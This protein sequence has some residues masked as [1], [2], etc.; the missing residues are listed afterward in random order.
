M[1]MKE[2]TKAKGDKMGGVPTKTDL[3]A[4]QL[5]QMLYLVANL[6]DA[7]LDRGF[8]G[9]VM[10][11]KGGKASDYTLTLGM[12]LVEGDAK[13]ARAVGVLIDYTKAKKGKTM[14]IRKMKKLFTRLAAGRST[15]RT[16][17]YFSFSTPKKA[18]AATKLLRDYGFEIKYKPGSKGFE[19]TGLPKA[20]KKTLSALKKNLV[21][22]SKHVYKSNEEAAQAARDRMRGK[23]TDAMFLAAD[24]S[25]AESLYARRKKDAS[26]PLAGKIRTEAEKDLER[27][28]EHMGDPKR[29][30]AIT[31]TDVLERLWKEHS[32]PEHWITIVGILE[33]RQDIQRELAARIEAEQTKVE[34]LS[35]QSFAVYQR[36][37][38]TG[39]FSVGEAAF[40]AS[41]CNRF[42]ELRKERSPLHGKMRLGSLSLEQRLAVVHTLRELDK[43]PAS[44][45]LGKT[46]GKFYAHLDTQTHSVL[47]IGFSTNP[48][49]SKEYSRE[50]MKSA[51]AANRRDDAEFK[52]ADDAART[53]VAQVKP[54]DYADIAFLL[55]SGGESSTKNFI[56]ALTS[57]K[58]GQPVI[59][60][61]STPT[62]M[63][64]FAAFVDKYY[65]E[66]E[67][68]LSRS[69]GEFG[70]WYVEVEK[71]GILLPETGAQWAAANIG[72]W[73][74]R[75]DYGGKIAS[76]IDSLGR[77]VFTVTVPAKKNG[78]PG[79][80]PTWFT[81]MVDMRGGELKPRLQFESALIQKGVSTTLLPTKV[82]T[83]SEY[84]RGKKRQVPV[85]HTYTI[86]LDGTKTRGEL[87]AAREKL[88]LPKKKKVSSPYLK[89]LDVGAPATAVARR[90]R[91]KKKKAGDEIARVR[92]NV[93]RK[94]GR[95]KKP[96]KKKRT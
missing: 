21:A 53:L 27:L 45:P 57:L 12:S 64:R 69:P 29:T 38:D 34:T 46:F 22:H 70:E 18:R 8:A 80:P 77:E 31:G 48:K 85:S 2:R 79:S 95:K 37:M 5:E 33:S 76:A 25:E 68:T 52:A 61:A 24:K 60:V 89:P 84:Y 11:K 63:A 49:Y 59:Y 43:L 56:Y 50:G 39:I 16:D 35:P 73:T 58:R 74:N 9:G 26:T 14:V 13:D 40:V 91:G 90:G 94:L 65:P 67:P 51:E 23:V 42:Q 62:E 1:V 83:R 71:P 82:K 96:P 3:Q 55:E 19:I 54:I 86:V 30:D 66:M 17:R 6:L 92:H 93:K 72:A 41:S 88:G 75:F 4:Q 81:R 87:W 44:G 7:N 20:Y 10:L 78:S 47:Y 28:L 32:I 15:K 36:L